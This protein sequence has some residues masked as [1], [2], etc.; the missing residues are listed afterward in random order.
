MADACQVRVHERNITFHF[1][2]S[3]PFH[4]L[5]CG[6][7]ADVRVRKKSVCHVQ[8]TSM[9]GSLI[10]KFVFFLINIQL[11]STV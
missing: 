1:D 2:Y 3:A 5:V 11:Q 9:R 8:S 10:L 7:E 4:N 6:P